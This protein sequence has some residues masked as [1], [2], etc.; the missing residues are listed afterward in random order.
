MV[1]DP[2][3]AN[4]TSDN[5]QTETV[6]RNQKTSYKN[7]FDDNDTQTNGTNR[8]DLIIIDQFKANNVSR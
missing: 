8:I 5:N 3:P 6:I 2:Q 1:R 4:T 7:R